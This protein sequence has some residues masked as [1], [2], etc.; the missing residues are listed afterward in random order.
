MVAP[1]DTVCGLKSILWMEVATVGCRAVGGPE[2]I[3]LLSL[4]NKWWQ[5]SFHQYGEGGGGTEKPWQV[6]A[7]D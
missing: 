3:R 4:G 5:A 7:R 2:R 6:G 1:R